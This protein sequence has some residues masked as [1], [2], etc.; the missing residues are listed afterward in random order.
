MS[1]SL[2]LIAATAVLFLLRMLDRR[3]RAS[4][5]PF[6]P[7]PPGDPIIG[8]LRFVPTE[9]VAEVYH[10]W[11][12]TYGDVMHL[13]VLGTHLIILSSH[14]A[15]VDLLEK[16]SAIYSDRPPF[17]LYEL[18][19]WSDSTP[20]LC[21]G[22]QFAKHRQA[23]QNYLSRRQC[24]SDLI[25][26]VQIDEARVLIKNL[27]Q[28]TEERYEHYITRFSTG[29]IVRLMCGHRITSDDDTFILLAD[30]IVKT[31]AETGPPGATPIDSFPF[32][33]HFPSWFPGAYYGGI[34]RM[35]RSTTRKLYE[36]PMALV[37]EQQAAG[38]TV[39]SFILSHLETLEAEGDES[40][41]SLEDIKASAATLFG[42]GKTTT[43][44]ALTIFV[45]AMVI[46]PECQR[47]AQSELDSVL[48]GRLPTLE[49]RKNL[50]YMECVFQESMR[51]NPAVPLG[52]PHRCT[53]DD[54]YRGMHIPKGAVVIS[55]I[56]GISQDAQIYHNPTAFEP[57][58]YLPPPLGRG[59]PYFEDVFGYGRRICVGMHLADAGVW[60][61]AATVLAACTITNALDE[62]GKVIV[63]ECI[64]SD[65]L[66]SHP[67]DFRCRI[68]RR[69]SGD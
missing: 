10:N 3:R 68:L 21:Y 4:R 65:G 13:D 34:A 41:F 27:L 44:N 42:A 18:L 30:M 2:V 61:A 31:L 32:L 12:K 50:P 60:I 49:D 67:K 16:K 29:V 54:T 28:S 69:S 37:R 45:L 53:E 23:H 56:R 64:L 26:S 55:N 36:Y 25:R 63:P 5:T 15:A 59:E 24:D 33:R 19:G 11:A 8:H 6:P 39:P 20:L 47:R 38:E 48:G 51:W 58:R 46:F 1:M 35:W 9:H 43:T 14:Q 22:K 40:K 66:D 17:I 57:E 52:V 7:G 62:N